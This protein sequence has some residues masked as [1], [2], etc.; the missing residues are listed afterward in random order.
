MSLDAL[1]WLDALKPPDVKQFPEIAGFT[2][3]CHCSD[4]GK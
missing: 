4:P 2:E 1:M 3:S